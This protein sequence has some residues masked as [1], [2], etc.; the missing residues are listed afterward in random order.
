MVIEIGGFDENFEI[1]RY[2]KLTTFV[3]PIN[4]SGNVE[5]LEEVS[6]EICN[7]GIV[8][9]LEQYGSEAD[10]ETIFLCVPKRSNYQL[11]RNRVD[12]TFSI[13][14]GYCN[15]TFLSQINSSLKCESNK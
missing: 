8:D 14:I 4:T 13:N 3:E 10:D 11:R 1:L 5:D 6:L 9:S 7:D 2:L 15:Q 12:E